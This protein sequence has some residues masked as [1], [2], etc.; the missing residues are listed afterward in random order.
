MTTKAYVCYNDLDDLTDF[1]IYDSMD[2]VLDHFEYAL[3][4]LGW[5]LGDLI[6]EGHIVEKELL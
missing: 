2:K 1:V 3:D 4:S 5:Q 6:K